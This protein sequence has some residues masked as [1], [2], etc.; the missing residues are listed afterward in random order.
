MYM[1]PMPKKVA[2]GLKDKDMKHMV[3]VIE[4]FIKENSGECK[5]KFIWSKFS[6]I[7]TLA[8]FDNI[9]EDLHRSGKIA[10]D[11]ETKIGWIWNPKL[12]KKYRNRTDLAFR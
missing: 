2:S 9:I 4:L 8:E 10:I 12:A 7:M 5:R 6:G 1:E 3:S 11:K